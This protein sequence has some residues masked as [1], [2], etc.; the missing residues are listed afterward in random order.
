MKEEIELARMISA[1]IRRYLS[2]KQK[3]GELIYVELSNDKDVLVPLKEALARL[4]G[5][6]LLLKFKVKSII[7]SIPGYDEKKHIELDYISLPD[8]KEKVIDI[9]IKQDGS[10]FLFLETGEIE[11][12]C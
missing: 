4:E 8:L 1:R 7:S 2:A 9:S 12:N 5:E 11:H 10:E 3:L 6:I